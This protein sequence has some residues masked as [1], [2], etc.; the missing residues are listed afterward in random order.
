M[1]LNRRAQELTFLTERIRQDF[2]Y[3]KDKFIGKITIG[4]NV[5]MKPADIGNGNF[6]SFL[7][8]N[9]GGID[10]SWIPFL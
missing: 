6:V 4:T 9:F 5:V 8:K 10:L 3:K 2:M 7:R 1:L